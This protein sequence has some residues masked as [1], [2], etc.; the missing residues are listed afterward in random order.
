MWVG[1]AATV[2]GG[3]IEMKVTGWV[4]TSGC[5]AP[6]TRQAGSQRQQQRV[7]GFAS[8]GVAIYT[9]KHSDLGGGGDGGGGE[10]GGGL[11]ASVMIG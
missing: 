7:V 8:C 1:A 3:C 11:Q 2:A 5:V 4:G 9:I 6:T 10:G